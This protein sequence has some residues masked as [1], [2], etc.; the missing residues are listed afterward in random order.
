MVRLNENVW[1]KW[2]GVVVAAQQQPAAGAKLPVAVIGAGFSGTIAALQLLRRLPADQ[3]VILLEKA[4]S[5]ARGVAYSGDDNQH[6]LNV[7]AA[8][9]SALAGEPAHFTTWLSERRLRDAGSQV[10][11]A[12]ASDGVWSTPAGDFAE[13]R[14]YGAYLR[15]LLDSCLA[16]GRLC[17]LH[18]T[19][20]DVCP[21]DGGFAIGCQSGRRL[22]ASGVVLAM[23]NLPAE[24]NPHPRVCAN[25]WSEKA[26]RPLAPDRPVMI[27]GT[28]LTM[29]DLAIALRRRGFAGPI[30]AVSRG[31][32]LPACHMPG[33]TMQTPYFTLAEEGALSK[34]MM[35]LRDEIFAAQA[36][37][38]DW[39]DVIDSL[40]PV[41]A[42]LWGNFS[43]AERARF[44][45]HARRYWEV[46]RHRMAPPNADA[47]AAMRN[48]GSLQILAARIRAI[49]TSDSGVRV[50]YRRRHS[51]ELETATVQRV[52]MAHGL[53]PT[54]QS[55]D[56]L[57]MQMLG[58]GLVRMDCM[59]LGLDAAPD[60]T[61]IGADG[62]PNPRIWAL[63]PLVRG[64][65][66]ESVA[67]PDIREQAAHLAVSVIAHL[68]T[69]ALAPRLAHV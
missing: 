20:I 17:L 57:V 33:R 1:S 19:V 54:N 67:V 5:F 56:A 8:N 66:W 28:G 38:Y 46:H 24:E 34:L 43:A 31:G 65:F 48:S 35:R 36:A 64:V 52:I 23:G 6:L 13:R 62:V 4:G 10:S 7:R 18:E 27:I 58:R 12:A 3:N 60:L 14:V 2:K 16:G 44:L 69:A 21:I 68:R 37:G 30:Q 15:E 9:M 40:R 49:E 41:T 45:R 25:P 63:G 51:K 47:I 29:V 55:E 53:L 39:R 11:D 61:V 59:G 26:L 50:T 32:L 22:A 42:R